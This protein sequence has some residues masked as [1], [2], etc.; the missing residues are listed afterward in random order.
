MK[1]MNMWCRKNKEAN[2]GRNYSE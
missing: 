2:V 1:L